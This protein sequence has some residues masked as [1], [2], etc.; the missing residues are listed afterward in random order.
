MG[1]NAGK[2]GGNESVNANLDDSSGYNSNRKNKG[3]NQ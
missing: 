1:L 3:S 2:C